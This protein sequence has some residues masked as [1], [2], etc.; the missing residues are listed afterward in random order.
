M[1]P[2]PP[3]PLSPCKLAI[4]LLACVTTATTARA[5]SLIVPD[6]APT[7]QLALDARADSVLVRPGTYAE[8]P[9]VMYD[10]SVLAMSDGSSDWVV[11]DT[12]KTRAEGS[13]PFLFRGLQ[14]K[15]PVRLESGG[16]SD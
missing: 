15:G 1:R 6:Q 2:Q 3:A 7:I 10:V 16:V 9:V 8:S 4:L 13:G 14:I 11:I 5:T 12:L